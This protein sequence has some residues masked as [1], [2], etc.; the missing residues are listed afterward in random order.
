MRSLKSINNYSWDRELSLQ[1]TDQDAGLPA[2][3]YV[4]LVE[5]VFSSWQRSRQLGIFHLAPIYGNEKQ[6]QEERTISAMHHT[7]EEQI[8]ISFVLQV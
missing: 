6:V 3:Q 7:G 1:L 8:K 4:V 5:N 2:Q